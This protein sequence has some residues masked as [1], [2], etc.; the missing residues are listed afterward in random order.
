MSGLA[1]LWRDHR[2]AL[3]AFVAAGLLT[4]AFAVRFLA[5]TL[6]WSDPDNLARHP[7]G[8]MTPGYVAR[9]WGIPREALR[10]ALAL[11]AGS[12]TP[13]TLAQIA[14]DRGQPLAEF[15]A[16]VEALLPGLAVA[17]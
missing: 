16:E 4:L 1:R 11:P 2:L 3:L 14:R 6:Y 13:P 15:L 7:E 9:S 17:P 5:F 10:T 12:G 8:W